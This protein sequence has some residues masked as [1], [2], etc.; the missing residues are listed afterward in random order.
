MLLGYKELFGMP[1]KKCKFYLVEKQGTKH[2]LLSYLNQNSAEMEYN[3]TRI[4]RLR[5]MHIPKVVQMA[6]N[7]IVLDYVEGVT[8]YEDLANGATF[9]FG[10]IAAAFAKMMRDVETYIPG[11]RVGNVD[12]RSYIVKGSVLY[13]F[14]FDCIITGTYVE[15]IADCIL[16]V[17]SEKGI[18]K[19]RQASFCKQLVKASGADKEELTTALQSLIPLC[20][21]LQ[22]KWEEIVTAI[23]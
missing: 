17:M 19:E 21:R 6:D 8:M 2:F 3:T 13:S 7:D 10:M 5:G 16:A 23:L 11:K 9:K 1:L 20:N 4:L 22:W 14:D 15:A 12:L 18:A